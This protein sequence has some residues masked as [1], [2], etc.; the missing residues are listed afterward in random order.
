MQEVGATVGNAG[1]DAS[2]C[3]AHFGAVLGTKLFLGSRRWAFAAL[4]IG[5]EEV[6]IVDLLTTIEDDDMVQSEINTHLSGGNRQWRN[7]VFEQKTDKVAACGIPTDRDRRRYRAY[8]QGTR[9]VD[10][11]RGLHLGE[12][13]RAGRRLPPE[14]RGGVLRR[15]CPC[16]V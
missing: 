15:L 2:D 4:L 8:G 9:P 1:M 6:G 10:V 3:A 11:Q 12:G 5:G 7:L 13:E 16:F 14:G